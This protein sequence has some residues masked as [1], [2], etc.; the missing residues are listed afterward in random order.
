[1]KNIKNNNGKSKTEPDKV[2]K[3]IQTLLNDKLKCCRLDF[4]KKDDVE[5]FWYGRFLRV[6]Y[7][8]KSKN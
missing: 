8:I 3:E 7:S 4:S 5:L 2:K 1:M 6:R